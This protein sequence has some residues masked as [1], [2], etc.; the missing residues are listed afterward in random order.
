MHLQ[1]GGICN[2]H[3]IAYCPQN[4]PVKAFRK[5]VSSWRRHRQK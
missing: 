1:C 3:A 4:V 2:N 5:S